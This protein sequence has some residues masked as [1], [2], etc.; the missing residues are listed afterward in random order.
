MKEKTTKSP[1]NPIVLRDVEEYYGKWLV[2]TYHQWNTFEWD[3]EPEKEA[4][5]ECFAKI[6]PKGR[7]ERKLHKICMELLN[8]AAQRWLPTTHRS[9]HYILHTFIAAVSYDF[10]SLESDRRENVGFCPL[11][12]SSACIEGNTLWMMKRNFIF[13]Q[14]E[15]LKEEIRDGFAS[16]FPT[17]DENLG[18]ED[19]DDYEQ[20]KRWA[21]LR[22]KSLNRYIREEKNN[23]E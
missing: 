2:D 19:E 5:R 7:R 1:T 6:V 23:E 4:V 20:Q 17:G 16:S 3:G 10:Y 9:K 18:W 15:E 12:Y 8:F 22:I 21:Q 13:Y 14:A 11:E